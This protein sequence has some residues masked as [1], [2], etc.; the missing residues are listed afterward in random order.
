MMDE[1]TKAAIK[2][3][4]KIDSLIFKATE[5]E[6]QKGNIVFDDKGK[7]VRNGQGRKA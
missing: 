7:M 2:Q 1:N 6:I 4:R 3:V 5:E